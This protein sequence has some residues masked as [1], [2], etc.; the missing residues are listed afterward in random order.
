MVK[1]SRRFYKWFKLPVE[2]TRVEVTK[3]YFA[4][5]DEY[6]NRENGWVRIDTQYIQLEMEKE[7]AEK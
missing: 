6:I 7:D 5:G 1:N 4:E 2:G 3:D